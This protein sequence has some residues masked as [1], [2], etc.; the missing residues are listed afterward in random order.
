MNRDPSGFLTLPNLLSITR[1]LLAIPFAL[2][3]LSDMPSARVWGVV[4]MVAAA[5]TDKLDGALARHYGTISEWGRILDPVADKI[6]VA[7]AAIV[8]VV[9]GDVPVWLAGAILLRDGLILAGG[10]IL[11]RRKRLVVPSNVAGKWTVGVIALTLFLALLGVHSTAIVALAA[12]T[13]LM[14]AVSLLLYVRTFI[15][16]MNDGGGTHGIA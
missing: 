12:V 15:R 6:A 14:L 1:A 5:A 13:V 3:M 4:L 2:V 8:L 9:R 11:R 16:V 10:I 7:V